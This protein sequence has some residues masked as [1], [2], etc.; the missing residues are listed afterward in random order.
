[1]S[2]VSPINGRADC[3]VQG[4][5][6]QRLADEAVEPCFADTRPVLG[7]YVR[8]QSDHW[9]RLHAWKLA[10]TAQNLVAIHSRQANIE[11]HQVGG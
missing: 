10:Q 4:V 9:N 11:Q 6:I 5:D 8:C 1:M 2:L 7:G 3:F